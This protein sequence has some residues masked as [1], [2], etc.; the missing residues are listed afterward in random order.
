MFTSSNSSIITVIDRFALQSPA[1]GLLD[2]LASLP[3]NQSELER[4]YQH[5]VDSSQCEVSPEVDRLVQHMLTLL[6]SYDD[7]LEDAMQEPSF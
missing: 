4:Y 6:K 1:S 5:L 7:S 2:T 3:T